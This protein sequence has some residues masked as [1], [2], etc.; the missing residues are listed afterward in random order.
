[1][2]RDRLR[3]LA[4]SARR[5]PRAPP[6]ER[7]RAGAGIRVRANRRRAPRGRRRRGARAPQGDAGEPAL[8]APP[9][10]AADAVCPRLA[11]RPL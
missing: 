1:M 10:R 6:R 2:R 3:D 11:R 4:Q 5:A 9:A 8:D 7:A